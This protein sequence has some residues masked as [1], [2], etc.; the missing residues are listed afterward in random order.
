MTGLPLSFCGHAWAVWAATEKSGCANKENIQKAVFRLTK[1]AD[2]TID[3]IAFV[4]SKDGKE[5]AFKVKATQAP[6]YSR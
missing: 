5:G 6:S 3:A 1:N 2:G 4:R